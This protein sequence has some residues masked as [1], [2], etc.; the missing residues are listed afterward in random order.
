M[1]IAHAD[2]RIVVY[3]AHPPKD[4]ITALEREAK[5]MSLDGAINQM[6]ALNPNYTSQK[7]LKSS[8]RS[9][10]TPPLSGLVALYSGYMAMSD[11]DGLITFPLRHGS[12]KIYVALTPDVKVVTIKGNTFSHREFISDPNVPAQLF[13]FEMK[14]DEKKIWYWDVQEIPVPADKKIN[15]LTLVILTYPKNIVVP[16]GHI[17][18]SENTQLILPRLYLVSR[19]NCED[20]LLRSIDTR[21]YFEPVMIQEQKSSDFCIQK[22]ITNL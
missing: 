5:N 16:Q 19:S 17:M 1:G 14:Q 13:S 6:E 10:F 8:L 15:P 18:A 21:R 12:P 7:L 4:L 22:M 11:T 9:Y 3:L 2:S 20:A